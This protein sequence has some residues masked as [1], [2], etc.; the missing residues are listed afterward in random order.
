MLSIG[1]A[2]LMN[3]ALMILDEPTEGLAPIIV[4]QIFDK[5]M[6]LKKAGLTLLLVEQ[7]FHFALNLADEVSV[8]GRGQCIWTGAPDALRQDEELH[9]RWIGV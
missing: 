7:N 9:K 2:L 5:L 4:R 3:P 6:E 1:R 8:M